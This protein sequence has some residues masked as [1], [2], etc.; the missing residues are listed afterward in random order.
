MLPNHKELS[1]IDSNKTQMDYDAISLYPS[2][3]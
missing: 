3:M 2:A 1:K